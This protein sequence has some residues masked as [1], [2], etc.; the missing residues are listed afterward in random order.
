MTSLPQDDELSS[1]LNDLDDLDDVVDVIKKP[2]S[3]PKKKLVVETDNDVDIE[4]EEIPD[5]EPDPEPDINSENK[6]E[7]LDSSIDELITNY[8]KDRKDIDQLISFLW[9]RLKKS[10][11]SRVMFE[12]LAVSLRTKSE[13]NSNLLKLIDIMSK[14][15]NSETIEGLDLEGLL[16]D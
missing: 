5:H 2:I 7:L 8:R 4:D 15:K 11:P 13:A 12:T 1:L 6:D 3:Q 14:R 9:N 16:D 10:D